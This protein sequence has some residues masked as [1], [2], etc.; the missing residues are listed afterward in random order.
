[1]A[2]GTRHKL[3]KTV[4]YQKNLATKKNTYNVDSVLPIVT[5]VPIHCTYKGLQSYSD[6]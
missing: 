2:N 4:V 5:Y 6:F 1:M 3:T